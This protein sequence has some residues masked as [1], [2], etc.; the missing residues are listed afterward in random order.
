M[1]GHCIKVNKRRLKQLLSTPPEFSKPLKHKGMKK[2]ELQLQKT[3]VFDD[4]V[5]R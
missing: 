3:T 4:V 5:L 1:N 2:L